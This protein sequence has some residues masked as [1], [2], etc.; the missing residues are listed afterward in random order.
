M[1]SVSNLAVWLIAIACGVI[2]E[3][4]VVTHVFGI[5]P[6][7]ASLGGKPEIWLSRFFEPAVSLTI[8]TAW[9]WSRGEDWHALGLRKPTS[10]RQFAVKVILTVLALQ[11]VISAFIFGV[12]QPFHFNIA[13]LPDIP[14]RNTLAAALAFTLLGTGLNQELLFRGFLLNRLVRAF[15]GRWR[16]GIVISSVVFGLF[17]LPLGAANAVEAGLAGIVLGEM[18]FRAE[19]NLWVVV[20]AHSVINA[21]GLMYGYWTY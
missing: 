2:A 17:H 4:L 9:L 3:N 6:Y 13:P 15:S 12:V 1:Y 5:S 19:K 20:V 8:L 10:W 16:E 11:G 21:I 18:Y 7:V 14:N